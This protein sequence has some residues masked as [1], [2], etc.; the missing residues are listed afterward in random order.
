MLYE[1]FGALLSPL[2]RF[3]NHLRVSQRIQLPLISLLTCLVLKFTR[4]Q[5]LI[6]ICQLSG[7]LWLRA[8]SHG[9]W[10]RWRAFERAWKKVS[11]VDG[12][13]MALVIRLGLHKTLRIW[14]E[15]L[16]C[17]LIL[18]LFFYPKPPYFATITGVLAPGMALVHTSLLASDI[19]R[20][21]PGKTQEYGNQGA[22]NPEK[23]WQ[24]FQGPWT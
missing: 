10:R 11:C 22:K 6:L 1:T 18:E 17:H 4:L 21:M 15:H 3:A 12:K 2:N 9:L 5:M 19:Y 8:N 13:A 20:Y 14:T 7:V 16:W 23:S 24:F